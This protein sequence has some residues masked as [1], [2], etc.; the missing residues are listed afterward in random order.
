MKH[1]MQ[2]TLSPPSHPRKKIKNQIS[3]STGFE[4]IVSALT[5]AAVFC[6]MNY[7]EPYIVS[8]PIC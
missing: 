5:L 1:E 8:S 2:I 4:T 6:Q 7:K 3:F